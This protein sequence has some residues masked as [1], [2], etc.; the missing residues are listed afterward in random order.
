MTLTVYGIANCDTVKRARAWLDAQGVEH[1]FHDY[2]KAGVPAERLGDWLATLGWERLVNRNGTTWRKL[3]EAARARVSDAA[4][5]KALLL[6]QPSL[7]KRPLVEWGGGQLSVG[8]D[9]ADWQARIG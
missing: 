7:I 6:E 1:R 5:A 4:S 2:K 3:D 8:F 9:A